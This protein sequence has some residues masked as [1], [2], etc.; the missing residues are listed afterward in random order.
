MFKA[1]TGFSPHRFQLKIR[2]ERAVEMLNYTALSVAEIAAIVGYTDCSYF[3]RVFKNITGNTPLF[4]R[5]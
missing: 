4:Y 5:K 2:M 3:C 1:Y